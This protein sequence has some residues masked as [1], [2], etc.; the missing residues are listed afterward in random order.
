M[1]SFDMSGNKTFYDIVLGG[2]GLF[3]GDFLRLCCAT[4]KH[5]ERLS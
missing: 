3:T 2:D 1:G 4:D 5:L